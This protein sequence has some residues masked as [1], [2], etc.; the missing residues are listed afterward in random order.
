LGDARTAAAE[1]ERASDPRLELVHDLRRARAERAWQALQVD[2][3][4]LA[5]DQ[6][7]RRI[8]TLLAAYDD[9]EPI[10]Q[11]RS[12]LAARLAALEST[13]RARQVQLAGEV[14]VRDQDRWTVRYR[15]SSEQLVDWQLGQGWR[16]E[17]RLLAEPGGGAASLAWALLPHASWIELRFQGKS[18]VAPEL[19][20]AWQELQGAAPRRLLIV[21]TSTG[22]ISVAWAGAAAGEELAAAALGALTAGVYTLAVRVDGD[23][24]EV[25]FDGSRRLVA[26]IPIAL[27][28]GRLELLAPTTPLQ[29][30]SVTLSARLEAMPAT[31]HR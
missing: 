15:F 16:A 7:A 10:K 29:V 27:T 1:L 19:V 8:A 6:L 3:A 20:L 13:H 5:E 21:L 31:T 18:G 25:A 24:V 26:R 4:Q 28:S 23:V 30:L 12:R 22:R 9:L 14:I 17:R 2:E 11:E